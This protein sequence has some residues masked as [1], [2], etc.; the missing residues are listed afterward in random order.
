[1]CYLLYTGQHYDPLLGPPPQHERKFPPAADSPKAAAAR[2]TAALQI[3]AA[4]NEESLCKALERS[5]P[6]GSLP[7]PSPTVGRRSKGL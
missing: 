2:E 3:A 6:A 1:M 5:M 7:H 4:H